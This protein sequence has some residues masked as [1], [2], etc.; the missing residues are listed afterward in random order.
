MERRAG[1]LL[2]P[3][4]LPGDYGIGDL[5]PAAHDWIDFLHKSGCSL[6]QVLPLGPTGY[7]DSPYQTFSAFA[8][9]PN[10]IS[11]DLL[12]RTH[13]LTKSE[14][15]APRFVAARVDYGPVIEWKNAILD[16]AYE[17]L[18][19]RP[20]ENPAR[21]SFDAFRRRNR[22]WL[23]DFALFMAL[24]KQ[25]DMRPWT[26]W[27]KP[28][29]DREAGAIRTARRRMS[30][31][32]GRVAF[33]QFVFE[34]QWADVRRAASERKIAIIGDIPIFVAHDSADVWANRHLFALNAAG[35]PR[36]VAGVPPDYFSETGQLWGNPLYRW[37]V[38]AGDNY[39]WWMARVRRTLE[40]VDYVRLDHFR[41]FHDY[42]EIPAGSTTAATGR[43][44]SGPGPSLFD[45]LG[46]RFP[47]MPFLAEDLGGSLGPGV[48]ALRRQFRLP[49]MKV[50]TFAFGAGA[51]HEFL[52]HNYTDTNWVAYTGTHDNQ[53]AAAWFSD[54]SQNERVHALRYLEAT[55]SSFVDDLLRMTWASIASWAIAPMQDVLGLGE[56]SRMNEPSV[57]SGNWQWRMTKRAASARTAQKLYVLNEIFGRLPKSD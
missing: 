16:A 22:A 30:T 23:T 7:G 2:H 10:L 54:A 56:E 44:R 35:R 12:R 37:K 4:S 24:K 3:T 49:G 40:L 43:W 25:H 5:G 52:P 33:G 45:A 14:I 46:A 27:P 26:E 57:A 48:E 50:T 55:P 31:E 51:D 53:P 42:W 39:A 9:N 6:W 21:V 28:L 41:G 20:K 29:R 34:R 38:H 47:T 11:P 17:R 15:Q 1:I 8:G 18:L 13:L 19:S 36:V 32:I